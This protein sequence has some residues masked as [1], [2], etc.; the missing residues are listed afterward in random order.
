MTTLLKCIVLYS[1]SGQRSFISTPTGLILHM[2][3][4]SEFARLALTDEARCVCGG[5]GG[6]S[7]WMSVVG[8][9]VAH[10]I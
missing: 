5:G 9:N 4:P 10:H 1:Y 3:S 2:R 7:G 6:V 8:V